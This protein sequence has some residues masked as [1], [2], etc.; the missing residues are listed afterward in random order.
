MISGV[1]QDDCIRNY[2]PN[3]NT[4]TFCGQSFNIQGIAQEVKKIEESAQD[5][6]ADLSGQEL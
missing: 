4:Y 1:K 5:R 6:K 3:N 2:N